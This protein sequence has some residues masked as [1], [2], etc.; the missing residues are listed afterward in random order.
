MKPT[1]FSRSKVLCYLFLSSFFSHKILIQSRIIQLLA[2]PGICCTGSLS[3]SSPM[4]FPSFASLF[5]S[6]SRAGEA[7]RLF[8]AIAQVSASLWSF[9]LLLHALICASASSLDCEVRSR[10]CA[11]KALCPQVEHSAW[12]TMSAYSTFVEWITSSLSINNVPWVL[13]SDA[14]ALV[15]K[16]AIINVNANEGKEIVCFIY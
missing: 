14:S 10:H 2:V 8:Q 3:V 9:P 5:L 4:L 13:W 7:T 16:Y 11:Y 12:H 6:P 1:L 15:S